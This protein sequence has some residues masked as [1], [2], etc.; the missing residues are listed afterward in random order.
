MIWLTA[1]SHFGHSNIIRHCHRPFLS[2][3]EMNESIIEN[4]NSAVKPNDTLFHLGDFAWRNQFAHFRSLIRC[5]RIIL[6]V[7]NHDPI[8]PTGQPHPSLNNVFTNAFTLYI[9]RVRMNGKKRRVILS[10]Y[11]L[12]NS[13]GILNIHGHHHGTIGCLHQGSIDVG[14]DCWEFKPISLDKGN[15]IMEGSRCQC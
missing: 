15:Q 12:N 11:A 5:K 13:G 14:V 7:G 1:D 2:V 8:T 10:H 4:I 6:I 9:L 3:E